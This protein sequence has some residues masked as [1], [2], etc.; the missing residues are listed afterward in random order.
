MNLVTFHPSQGTLKASRL[1]ST[2]LRLV[3][4][5]IGANILSP[6]CGKWTAR[7]TRGRGRAKCDRGLMGAS[8]LYQVQ[9]SWGLAFSFDTRRTTAPC[10]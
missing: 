10:V 5:C 9:T 6:T 1:L 7:H 4:S 3:H 8:V 2:Q